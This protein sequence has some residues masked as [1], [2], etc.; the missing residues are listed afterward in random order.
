MVI[1][2][3]LYLP[4][5]LRLWQSVRRTQ[6]SRPRRRSIRREQF[7]HNHFHPCTIISNRLRRSTWE[8]YISTLSPPLKGCGRDHQPK[9]C[10]CWQKYARTEALMTGIATC[11]YAGFCSIERLMTCLW[12]KKAKS[13]W[14]C[15]KSLGCSYR[16]HVACT[17]PWPQY[18][19][20]MVLS[21]PR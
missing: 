1:A 19:R 17:L 14:L 10:R 3:L 21:L 2:I 13:S 4:E 18:K 6:E 12:V 8:T 9:S 20:L 16:L 11:T 5:Y 7:L 15:R